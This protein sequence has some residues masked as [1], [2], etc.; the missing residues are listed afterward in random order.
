LVFDVLFISPKL[1]KKYSIF[2]GIAVIFSISMLL[3][4]INAEYEL[5]IDENNN[6]VYLMSGDNQIKLEDADKYF[7]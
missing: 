5:Q 3:N 2:F 7:S 1:M 4:E 6:E